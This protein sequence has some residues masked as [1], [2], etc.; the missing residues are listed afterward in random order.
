L[1][2]E[3]YRGLVIEN[4]NRQ[5]VRITGRIA[6]ASVFTAPL[7]GDGKLEL[8][9]DGEMVLHMRQELIKDGKRIGSLR[10]DR[11]I[12]ALEKALFNMGKLGSTSELA[13]CVR[14]DEQLV[15]L[16][17]NKNTNI[18][19]V[20]L[21]NRQSKPLPM[22]MALA[23]KS[24]I[25]YTLDHRKQNVI[26]A[27]GELAPG[28][29]FVAKQDAKEAYAVI[30]DA[31]TIG[32]PIILIVSVFGAL[33]L[34]SQLNPAVIRMRRSEREAEEAAIETQTIMGAVGD[35][36]I[37]ID[38]QGIIQSVNNAACDI[39]GYRKGELEG[40]NVSILMPAD[41]SEAHDRALARV[42]EGEPSRLLG[43]PN[44]QVRG[45]KKSG[46]EFPLEITI[47]AVPL[48]GRKLFVGVMRDIT[49]RKETEERLSRL[50]QYDM[51]TGLPN[52]ALFMDRLSAAMLRSKRSGSVVVLMF[53]DLDGFK[54]V[55]DVFGHQGGDALLVQVAER[56]SSAVRKSDTVARLAG[57][58]FT[59]IL[60]NLVNPHE[61]AKAIAEKIVDA[62]RA[63]FLVGN[64]SANVTASVGLAIHDAREGDI[65]AKKLLQHA[66]EQ[67]YA[68]KQ[69]GKN[70][71]S[72]EYA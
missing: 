13:V 58:E 6:D 52:R 22:E 24:G 31:L 20:D 25:V 5:P 9:W 34:Y 11:A 51:L 8:A 15:C 59:V 60:E 40:R 69:A 35:G 30:R 64:R 4:T 50:A 48:S 57:D 19:T 68:A 71:F 2:D 49:S 12:P 63:P 72:L 36:I 46:Q 53:I 37:T 26:A 43:T 18:F 10:I 16:P 66:D 17:N 29:G 3:G 55:N 44:I 61:D 32:V 38:H 27:Y 7:T 23:G 39:F 33:L 41:M 1:V 47:N 28:I 65:D 70:K 56:L 67:M 62:I 14:R 45:L 54:E 21:H 42:A